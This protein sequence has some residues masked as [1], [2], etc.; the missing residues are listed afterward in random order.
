VRASRCRLGEDPTSFDFDNLYQVWAS[1]DGMVACSV[2]PHSPPWHE[3]AV[4]RSGQVEYCRGF[5]DPVEATDAPFG[6]DAFC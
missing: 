3:V 4:L 2:I 6:C 1:D 5:A